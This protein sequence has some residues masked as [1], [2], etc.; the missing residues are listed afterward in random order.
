M[1]TTVLLD[2]TPVTCPDATLHGAI[3]A[4][5]A[6]AGSRLIVEVRADGVVID[7][8]APNAGTAGIARIEMSSADP[9][10]LA[11]AA[12]LDG[13]DRLEEIATVQAD[14]AGFLQT[15]ETERAMGLLMRSREAWGGVVQTIE[16]ICQTDLL[17][18]GA[19]PMLGGLPL[20]EAHTRLKAC[21]RSVIEALTAQDHAALADVLAYD[22]GDL[23][24]EWATDLRRLAEVPA[25]RG[26]GMVRSVG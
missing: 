12:L 4:G 3:R 19:P 17:A 11:R 5:R 9:V 8:D 18:T 6:A 24:R 14:A 26:S 20:H 2:G 22:L 1:A 16:L 25:E 13:A 21:L 7:P 23:A 10:A 15:G